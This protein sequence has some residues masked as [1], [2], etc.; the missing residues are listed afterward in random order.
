MAVKINKTWFVLGVALVIG[1]AAALAA[2]HYLSAK[3]SE[4]Q[5][6]LQG[7]MVKLVVAR[8]DLPK[9]AVLTMKSVAS[10]SVPAE[11]AQSGAVRP[12]QFNRVAGRKLSAPLRGGE[13]V[14]WG[15]VEDPNTMAFSARV[16]EGRRAISVPVDEINSLSGM[17]QPGDRIDLYVSLE[18]QKRKMVIPV[19]QNLAVLAA[20]N[21]ATVEQSTGDKR[22]YT[23]IT[24]DAT[25]EEAR[26]VVLARDVGRLTA[27]L[28]NPSDARSI[29]MP[30]NVGALLAGG[31]PVLG[32]PKRGIPILVGGRA[33]PEIPKLGTTPEGASLERLAAA[34][35]RLSPGSGTGSSGSTAS[36]LAAPLK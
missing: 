30:A 3:L 27:M 1:V 14:M 9:G 35:E 24:L 18:R 15:L 31:P 34:V 33:M 22:T 36:P 13:F 17:L 4:G 20:G 32:T 21:R 25:T 23:T 10:R 12:D 11:Y 16:S 2:R 26:I 19:L 28:R 6:S 7:T 8:E 29:D 5:V